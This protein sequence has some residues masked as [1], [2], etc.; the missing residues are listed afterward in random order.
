MLENRKFTILIFFFV[1]LSSTSF[2]QNPWQ[3]DKGEFLLSPYLSHYSAAAFRNRDGDKID[4]ENQ[5]KF[6]NYNP[7]IYF[8]LPLNGYKVNLFG[9]LPWF[10]NQYEDTNLRQQNRDLGDIE[11]GARFHLGK[12][13]MH[14]LMASVTTF[15]P[16]Y[17]NNQ[18][19]YTGFGRFGVEGRLILSGNSP[20]IG[21]SNNF[22]KIELG[23]R[24]FFPSDPGQIRL[25]SSKGIRIIDKFVLLGEIDAIFSFSNDSDFFENNLQL[26]SD[27]S[28]IKATA[29]I[30]YEFTPKFSLYGGLFHDVLNRNS[31]IGSGFQIFSVIRFDKK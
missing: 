7:R 21:E 19:P 2:A 10:F 30:G 9:S 22:H 31:G 5:G 15:I 12:V 11:L 16:A 17:N 27:F 23:Y 28:V 29:N 4:F 25:F 1:V 14:Y 13:N 26:V 3:Q 20:W 8:S 18:L 6:V 24:Y